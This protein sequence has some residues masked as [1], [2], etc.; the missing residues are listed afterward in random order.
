MPDLDARSARF[1][2]ENWHF[3]CCYPMGK[4]AVYLSYTIATSITFFWIIYRIT[5][6]RLSYHNYEAYTI[7]MI[8]H[9]NHQTLIITNIINNYPMLLR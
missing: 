1:L 7:K 6:V 3:F 4:R 5:S 8:C 9:I 2:I